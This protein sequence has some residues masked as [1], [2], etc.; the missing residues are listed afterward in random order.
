MQDDS[1]S[2]GEKLDKFFAIVG[3][4]H[5]LDP[6]LIGKAQKGLR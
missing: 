6:D 4:L 3:Y 5:H 2:S 1:I